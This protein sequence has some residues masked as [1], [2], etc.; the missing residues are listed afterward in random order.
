MAK[1]EGYYHFATGE[2]VVIKVKVEN[3]FPD[4]VAEARKTC[5]DALRELMGESVTEVEDD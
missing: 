4:A 5:V 2:V 1:V 3:S